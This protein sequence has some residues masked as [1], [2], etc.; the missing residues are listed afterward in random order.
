MPKTKIFLTI[1]ILWV[2]ELDLCWTMK[3]IIV[4]PGVALVESAENIDFQEAG[5]MTWLFV[6]VEVVR[7]A[8]ALGTVALQC[9]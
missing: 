7:S 5:N 2:D 3:E 1:L 8:L 9:A 4:S 6:G